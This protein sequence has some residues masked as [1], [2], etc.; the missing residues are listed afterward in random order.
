MPAVVIAFELQDSLAAGVGAGE[1]D[2]VI[3]RL[4]ARAAEDHLVGRRDHPDEALGEL[5]LERVGGRERD[6]VLVH[7]RPHRP[8]DPGVVVTQEDRPERG[9][10][11][12][13]LVAVHIPGPRALGPGHE[14][15]VGIGTAALALDTARRHRA[16]APEQA[17]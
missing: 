8:V 15:R 2:G 5:H 17:L 1:A 16:G 10:E 12:D 13:E 14:Q 6:T 11:V 9:M 3:G 4:A 7:R